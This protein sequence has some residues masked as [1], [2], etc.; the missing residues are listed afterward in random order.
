MDQGM[1]KGVPAV[2]A[3]PLGLYNNLTVGMH[4]GGYP[5]T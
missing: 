1:T 4:G 5:S 2:C 3:A